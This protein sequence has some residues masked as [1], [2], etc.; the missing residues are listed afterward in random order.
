MYGTYGSFQPPQQPPQQQQ[1][2][3]KI[4]TTTPLLTTKSEDATPPLPPTMAPAIGPCDDCK[5]LIGIGF[6]THPEDCDKFVQC[7]FGSKGQLRVAYRQ[8]PFGQYWDQ[9]PSI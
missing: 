8:C 7:Y 3:D 5:M 1:Q 4:P 2:P 9:V 6:N